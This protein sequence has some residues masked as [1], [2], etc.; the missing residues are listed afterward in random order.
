MECKDFLR[1]WE[2]NGKP[3]FRERLVSLLH[4]MKCKECREAHSFMVKLSRALKEEGRSDET[5]FREMRGRLV[6][7]GR[8]AGILV[9]E[10]LPSRPFFAFPRLLVPLGG[11]LLALVL[12]FFLL[13]FPSHRTG[14][15]S[16]YGVYSWD[17]MVLVSQ[18]NGDELK[19]FEE[20]LEG[21][22]GNHPSLVYSLSITPWAEVM[23]QAFA[24]SRFLPSL[25][26]EERSG[27]M[28]EKMEEV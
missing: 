7:E 15:S 12:V 28:S 1:S 27:R 23:D 18:L 9:S 16:D 6:E 11:A 5:F 24:N 22:F 19:A 4:R 13:R 21:A 8:G 25:F 14:V 3:S 17:G 10:P 26:M 20:E 2:R